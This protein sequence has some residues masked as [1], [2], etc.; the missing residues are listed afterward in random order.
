MM[1]SI[2]FYQLWSYAFLPL[3]FSPKS[4]LSCLNEYASYL[5]CLTAPDLHTKV[6]RVAAIGMAIGAVV[7]EKAGF[8]QAHVA[9]MSLRC[10]GPPVVD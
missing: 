6:G 9:Q 1:P 10:R 5:Q 7:E 3:Y 4:D 2:I 8:G